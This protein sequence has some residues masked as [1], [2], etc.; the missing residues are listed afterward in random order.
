MLPRTVRPKAPPIKTQGIKTKLVP[1]IASSIQW[2]GLGRWVEPFVGSGAVAFNVAPERALLADTNKHII[3]FYAGV[4]AGEITGFAARRFL[5]T[6]GCRLSEAGE[7]HYY[8][9]RDRFNEAG[10]PLDFLFLSRSCFNGVMRFNGK[11]RFNV[12]FCKKP[13]RFR[14]A[15]VTKIANQIDW[16]ANI[17]A[18]KEWH[19]VTQAWQD[20]IAQVLPNDMIYC[21]PPY[22][23]RHTDY[24]NRFGEDE[25][26]RLAASLIKERAPFALSMWLENKYRRNHWLDRWFASFPQKTN[27]HFYHVGSTEELRNEMTEVLIMSDNAYAVEVP[28][29]S[30]AIEELPLFQAI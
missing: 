2:S 6:E 28:A 15:L 18:G 9:I 30:P 29:A 14:P 8:F 26:D 1:M 24:Y 12:P 22:V 27:A 3:A 20:T 19:F 16:S 23:G 4:Q 17:M 10:A 13:D 5:E 21:D 7:S 25:A 11:G